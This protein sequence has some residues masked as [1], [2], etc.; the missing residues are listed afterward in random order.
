LPAATKQFTPATPFSDGKE[1][2]AVRRS[3][4]QVVLA[5]GRLAKW[6][7]EAIEWSLWEV[8]ENVLNHSG[9][10][11]GWVQASTFRETKH[12]NIAVVDGGVGIRESLRE[13]YGPLTDQEALRK[14]VEEGGTRDPHRN[15]G[16]GLT[17]C[18]RIAQ[19]NRGELVVFSGGYL[20][21]TQPGSAR[22][23]DYFRYAKTDSV[24]NGTLVEV[25]LRTNRD[26]DPRR[27]FKNKPTPLIELQPGSGNE[28][29]FEVATEA[30]SLG[31]RAA[32]RELRNKILNLRQGDGD[33]RVVL[34]FSGIGMLSSS[35]ADELVARLAEELGV[36][37][38]FKKFELRGMGEAVET[39]IQTTLW[40]RLK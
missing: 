30:E 4:M 27:A 38:F 25:E 34:D 21:R 37:E 6:L 35:F 5:Q 16:Y 10:G 31:T 7:P 29:L 33:A 11:L 36:D 20:L 24:M 39:I 18:A 22:Q 19:A 14:A 40:S 2:D 9:V 8:M 1:L 15:A 26:I 23:G 32:G 3:I 17:G 12:I 28:Y 13:R